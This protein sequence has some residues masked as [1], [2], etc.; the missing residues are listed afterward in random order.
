MTGV[1]AVACFDAQHP[2]EDAYSPSWPDSLTLFTVCA[3]LCCDED[4]LG[5][6]CVSLDVLRR[7]PVVE[8][9]EHCGP[10]RARLG[11]LGPARVHQSHKGGGAVAWELQLF[12]A[13]ANLVDNLEGVEVLPGLPASEHL[14]H[15]H[16]EAE[17]VRL[18]GDLAVGQHLRR[19]VVRRA[20][21]WPGA[22]VGD[23]A[24]LL[25]PGQAEV[26][27]P[28]PPEPVEEHVVRAEI[29]VY[30]GRL[31]CV[32]ELKP[33]R[34]PFKDHVCLLNRKWRFSTRP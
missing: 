14:P 32:Q 11:A 22:R 25:P 7:D 34:N 9:L 26:A 28:R 6:S 27:D 21:A 12:V 29:A 24:V 4:L 10:L 33:L 19:H 20:Q 30:D 31:L 23:A 16:A 18:L 17:D 8:R 15:Q 13:E 5:A 2:R 1:P 3:F